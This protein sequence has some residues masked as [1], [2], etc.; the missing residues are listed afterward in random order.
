LGAAPGLV[1]IGTVWPVA[2][3]PIVASVVKAESVPAWVGWLDVGLASGVVMVAFSVD[4]LTRGRVDSQIGPVGYG[5]HRL[6]S[7]LLIVLLVVFFVFGDRIRWN[8]L[9]PGLAWRMWL[10][11]YIL[12]AGLTAWKN[13][14]ARS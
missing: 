1:G 5:L 7:H 6:A 2:D 9:L 4:A 11:L 3:F 12:P 13:V 14:P 8:V 10:L